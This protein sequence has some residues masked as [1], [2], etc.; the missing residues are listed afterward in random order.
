MEVLGGLLE[1]LDHGRIETDGDG[2]SDLDD[3]ARTCRRTPPALPRPVAMPRAV[4]AQ[5]GTELEATVEPKE[6]VL[7]LRLDLVDAAADD[8][9]H[10][11]H[12][13][14]TLPP[15]RADAAAPE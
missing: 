9:L 10:P 1:Q 3:Q 12:R 2:A 4:H 6:Q 11:R 7:A 8:P 14:R 15:G 13:A 5:V